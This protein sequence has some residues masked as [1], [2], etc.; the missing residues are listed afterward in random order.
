MFSPRA[1]RGLFI[2]TWRQT[3]P[4]LMHHLVWHQWKKPPQACSQWPWGSTK[5]LS[6]RVTG[7]HFSI[8]NPFF[9]E[10][11]KVDMEPNEEVEE[12]KQWQRSAFSKASRI[13]Q[14]IGGARGVFTDV[15][16]ERKGGGKSYRER[17]MSRHCTSPVALLWLIFTMP[18]M[19]ILVK[20]YFADWQTDS[21]RGWVISLRMQKTG[22]EVG[23]EPRSS[24]PPVFPLS[25]FG[26]LWDPVLP[27]GS[28]TKIS[29][30]SSLLEAAVVSQL[31]RTRG[32]AS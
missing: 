30:E 25:S 13:T 31:G 10:T 19:F 16:E 17:T 6:R 29:L 4:N 3:S 27:P 15:W 14:E 1:A 12:C 8:Q 28:P 21:P 18:F 32:K 24:V 7:S 23:F 22:A 26:L 20:L 5:R 9:R 11:A 2:F